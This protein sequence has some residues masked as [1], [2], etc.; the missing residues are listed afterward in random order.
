M[1]IFKELFQNQGIRRFLVLVILVLFLLAFKSMLNMM[2][3]TFIIAYLMNRISTSL[4]GR[5]QNVIRVGQRVVAVALYVFFLTLMSVA[6]YYYIPKMVAELQD[7]VQQLISFYKKP[8]FTADN[9][10][11]KYVMGSL[12]E[13]D[14]AQYINQG[15]DFLVKRISDIGKW[16]L[17]FFIAVILSFFFLME[18]AKVR[19]FISNMKRSKA[20]WFFQE[21]ESFGGKFLQSFGKVIEVQFMIATVNSILSTLMLWLM[22]FPHL[23]VLAVMIFLLGLIPV[24]GVIIS[25]I[26]LSVIAFKIGGIV[27]VVYVIVMIVLLHAFEAYFLNPKFM[28][29]KTHL[30]VFF[31]LSI[32]IASEH[33]Y[34]VWGLI[35]GIPIF[36]FLL[37]LFEVPMA[38]GKE[39][40]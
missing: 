37:D 34:G 4:T 17:N 27:K 26:P 38:K 3:I 35:L 2:L 1:T 24:A 25:L 33:L 6:I 32:L 36:I 14:L 31:T 10:V 23:I 22:G 40:S 21:L 30:P 5:L 20:G 16:S 28:S 12:Q 15:L 39:G 7:L 9:Q 19:R 8:A 13:M 11:L 18:K 29:S